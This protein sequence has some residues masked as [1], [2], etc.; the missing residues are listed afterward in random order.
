MYQFNEN[1]KLGACY[2]LIEPPKSQ[3]LF[4]T[5]KF[6]DSFLEKVLRSKTSI[7][8]EPTRPQKTAKNKEFYSKATTRSRRFIISSPAL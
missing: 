6:N 4:F 2:S 3:M 5:A 8:D 7:A 1:H